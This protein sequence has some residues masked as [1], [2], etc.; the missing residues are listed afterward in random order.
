MVAMSY[1]DG[2]LGGDVEKHWH[3]YALVTLKT[4]HLACPRPF[5]DAHDPLSG[6]LIKY[7]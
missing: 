6:V 4:T 2:I 3:S 5:L 7:V 1:V